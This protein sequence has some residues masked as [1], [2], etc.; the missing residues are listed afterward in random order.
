MLYGRKRINFRSSRRT[1]RIPRPITGKVASKDTPTYIQCSLAVTWTDNGS[2]ALDLPNS[3]ITSSADYAAYAALYAQFKWVSVSIVFQP[4]LASPITN[5]DVS[6]GMF[7]VR[8]GQYEVVPATLTVNQIA[9]LDTSMPINN[10]GS[11]QYMYFRVIRPEFYDASDISIS[12]SSTP[13]INIYGSYSQTAS[14][15]FNRGFY[16]VKVKMVARGRQR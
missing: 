1:T 4:Y 13:K 8:Q 7:G 9:A 15:N 16:Q 6:V 10:T 2:F 3:I 14:T 12:N 5:T 11:K